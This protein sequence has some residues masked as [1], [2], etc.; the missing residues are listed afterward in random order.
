MQIDQILAALLQINR[1]REFVLLD[2]AFLLDGISPARVDGL[3]GALLQRFPVFG[4]QRLAHF[5]SRFDGGEEKAHARDAHVRQDVF[6]LN[7]AEYALR[8]GF[9]AAKR[10]LQRKILQFLARKGLHNVNDALAQ[11]LGVFREVLPGKGVDGEVQ[12][13]GNGFRL[14]NAVGDLP[15]QG[16]GLKVVGAF[17]EDK[18]GVL[19]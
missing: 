16:D 8:Q 6:L 10:I 19:R 11:F 13:S 3:I 12:Q 7:L 15:L 2:F 14:D 18:E 9:G 17:V 1:G 4:F 5:G